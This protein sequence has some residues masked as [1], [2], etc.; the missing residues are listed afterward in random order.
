MSWQCLFVG[1]IFCNCKEDLICLVVL[2]MGPKEP[3]L[4]VI[5]AQIVFITLI[6]DKTKRI[7][8]YFMIRWKE[9]VDIPV[10]NYS[11]IVIHFDQYLL[12]NTFKL[13]VSEKND[14]TYLLTLPLQ[15]IHECDL[16][17]FSSGL[18]HWYLSEIYHVYA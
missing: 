10:N 8:S 7:C 18:R 1:K 4:S 17:E 11:D 14:I 16:C 2:Y 9:L 3:T 6:L 12:K 15:I 5:V 13:L